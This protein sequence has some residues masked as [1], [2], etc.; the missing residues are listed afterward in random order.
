M[1][2][3]RAC[4]RQQLARCADCEMAVCLSCRCPHCQRCE[5]CCDEAGQCDEAKADDRMRAMAAQGMIVGAPAAETAEEDS[6]VQDN[7]SQLSE[8]EREE[9]LRAHMEELLGGEPDPEEAPP[10]S[11]H[12]SEEEAG[13]EEEEEEEEE[14]L[15]RRVLSRTGTPERPATPEHLK[16]AAAEVGND[17]MEELLAAV[18]NFEVGG[19]SGK[20]LAEP[21]PE[22]HVGEGGVSRRRDCPFAAPPSPF[23]RCFNMDGEG[24]SVK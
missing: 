3:G 22:D 12:E 6:E 20:Y 10:G 7:D 21:E 13:E 16:I 14:A 18:T 19:S 8:D 23:S 15:I 11:S 1:L 24:M 5:D 2:N 9:R 4:A 17:G